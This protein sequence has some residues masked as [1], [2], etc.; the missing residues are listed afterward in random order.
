VLRDN[1]L[2][3][4]EHITH[5][6]FMQKIHNSEHLGYIQNDKIKMALE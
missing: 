4:G 2:T 3:V 1:V 6:H 5:V